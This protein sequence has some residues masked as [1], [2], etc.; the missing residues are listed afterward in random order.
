MRHEVFLDTAYAIAL[1]AP[2]DQHHELAALIAAQLKRDKTR[3]VTT[4][5]IALE[6]GDSLSGLRYRTSAVKLLRSLESDSRIDIIP[7][8]A[9]L[10]S[11][12]LKLFGERPDKAWGLTDCV[13]FVI[14]QDRQITEALTTDEH[15]QQAGFLPLL[16][17]PL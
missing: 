4:Q 2:D 10:Y 14:M 1:V 3:L 6:I 5:A 9:Q 7:L 13:S 11:R 15:F 17:Q 12:A 16:R 8:S